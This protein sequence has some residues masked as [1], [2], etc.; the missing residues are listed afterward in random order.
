MAF[1]RR[2]NSG[3]DLSGVGMSSRKVSGGRAKSRSGIAMAPHTTLSR[4]E[5]YSVVSGGGRSRDAFS[6][7]RNP[8]RGIPRRTALLVI[9]VALL[10]VSLA[11]LAGYLV[12]QQTVRNALK[13]E[14]DPN[15]LSAVLVPVEEGQQDPIPYW[16]ACVHTDASSAE[17]GRGSVVDL[18]LMHVD[19]DNK[20]LTLLWIPRDT[21]V[22]ID[23]YGYHDIGEAFDIG[24]EAGITAAVAKLGGVEVAHYIEA[25]DLGMGRLVE[26]LGIPH[27]EA[28][29]S[30]AAFIT[31]VARV[32]FG[33]SSEQIATRSEHLA[34]CIATDL[35]VE[36]LGKCCSAMQGMNTDSEIY[37]L[38]MPSVQQDDDGVARRVV[39]TGSWQ[40]IIAR[41]SNGLSPVATKKE[42]GSYADMRANSAIAIWNG[43]GVSGVAGDCAEELKKHGWNVESTGNAAQFVYDETLVVYKENEDEEMANLLVSDLGQGRVVRSAMRYSFIGDILVV[44]GQDYQ[45]Y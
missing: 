35:S 44:V 1:G 34:S 24:R 20:S 15:S 27:D 31:S 3:L 6:R 21:R 25:N 37:S 28:F 7:G 18:C 17:A 19:P 38:D 10:A 32:I 22:Y 14:I 41:V 8:G 43:V 4:S 39:D 5:S 45:P 11:A 16:V 30:S 26:L 23:G 9:V 36:G 2:K 40:T 12:Y 42:L 13:A 29:A 33:S